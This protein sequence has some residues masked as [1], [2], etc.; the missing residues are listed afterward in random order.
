MSFLA[1]LQCAFYRAKVLIVYVIIPLEVEVRWRFTNANLT[2][3]PGCA[4]AKEI[5]GE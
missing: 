1:A 3:V 2:V 4:F 5:R